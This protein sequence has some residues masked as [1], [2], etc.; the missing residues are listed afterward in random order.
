MVVGYHS[1]MVLSELAVAIN[2]LSGHHATS[3]TCTQGKL[4][5]MREKAVF[6]AT[7]QA[8]ID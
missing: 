4:H 8:E 7:I 6:R 1:L 3:R 5:T 2:E